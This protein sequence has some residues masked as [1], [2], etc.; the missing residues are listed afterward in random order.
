MDGAFPTLEKIDGSNSGVE[1]KE[2]SELSKSLTTTVS[3]GTSSSSKPAKR[4]YP[5]PASQPTQIASHGIRFDFNDGAR[6]VL[7]PRTAGKW[8][9]R[10][11]D[12]DTGNTLFQSENQGATVS[13]AKKYYVRFGIEVW[14]V[15]DTGAAIEVFSHTYDARDRDILIQFPVG[16]LGD[17]LAWF[18]YA[19]R[20]AEAHGARITC[21]MAE[22]IIPL[23]R[24]AYRGI[25]FVTHADVT[26]QGIAEQSYA[27]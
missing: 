18:P 11:R 16:T 27:T 20:F 8:R 23:L 15:D 2:F 7:P 21:A 13:S 26:E 25:R 1:N 17:T 24:D 4:P 14:E 10:L 5:P 12:I 9:I 6:V 19:V 22:V 3:V